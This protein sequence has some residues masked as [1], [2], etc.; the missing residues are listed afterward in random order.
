[1]ED[2]SR[3]RPQV[4]LGAEPAP[5]LVGVGRTCKVLSVRLEGVRGPARS[6]FSL[7]TSPRRLPGADAA[8][9]TGKQHWHPA[10]GPGPPAP[11]PRLRSPFPR[12]CAGEGFPLPPPCA[13]A[14]RGP[15]APPAGHKG[16][17]PGEGPA[18]Q[19]FAAEIRPSLL[20][21]ERF[22]P[23]RLTLLIAHNARPLPAS[24]QWQ[25]RK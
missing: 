18:T 23:P 5:G 11:R 10:R 9:W 15:G 21:P 25:T 19:P 17:S 16:K 4:L 8:Q 24:L 1:M 14:T 6:T 22:S 7:P 13:A 3:A 12:R 2:A 20:L